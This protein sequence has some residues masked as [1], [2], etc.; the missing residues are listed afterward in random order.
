MGAPGAFWGGF[1]PTA[2]DVGAQL[3]KQVARLGFYPQRGGRSAPPPR[4]TFPSRGKS[5]KA[6]QG[7]P[8]FGIPRCVAAALFALAA[9]RAGLPSATK[10]DRFATLSLWANRSCFFLW[11][12]QG[13]TLCFQSVARQ[14]GCPRGCLKVSVPATN[15][16]R[17]GGRGIKGGE[18][19]FAGGPGTR[20]FLAYLCLLS[21]REKVG[22]GAGRSARIE[23]CRDCRPAKAPG[24]G[25]VLPPIKQCSSAPRKGRRRCCQRQSWRGPPSTRPR[26]RLHAG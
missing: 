12:H 2:P 10:I 20:R 14:V 7:L 25:A 18:A 4:V 17:A 9:H 16:A 3:P 13:N 21:L 19:P 8:P 26:R 24:V 23:R 1:A 11:F 22:R 15:T 6:R 5:P